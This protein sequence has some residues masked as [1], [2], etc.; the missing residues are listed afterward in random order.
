[1]S[2]DLGDVRKSLSYVLTVSLLDGI[3]PEVNKFLSK[4]LVLLV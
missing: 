1:M 4:M 2:H 3:L